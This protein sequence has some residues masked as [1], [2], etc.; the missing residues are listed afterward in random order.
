M[1]SFKNNNN[2]N[3][4][5]KYSDSPTV[6]RDINNQDNNQ[7]DID[8]NANNNNHSNNNNVNHNKTAS[9]SPN[10]LNKLQELLKQVNTITSTL[11]PTDRS[12]LHGSFSSNQGVGGPGQ[13]SNCDKE[14]LIHKFLN[15]T[16]QKPSGETT[17]DSV[18]I[19]NVQEIATMRYN[20]M[21]KDGTSKRV[22]G[23]AR[24]RN[25]TIEETIDTWADDGRFD[26]EIMALM[27]MGPNKSA[28]RSFMGTVNY[29]KDFIQNLASIAHPL[30]QLTRKSVPFIW[31][32][33]VQVAFDQVKC[34]VAN[35]VN[36]SLP[37]TNYPFYLEC[38]ASNI[39]IGSVLYQLINGQ[40]KVLAFMSRKLTG[41]PFYLFHP[42]T[43]GYISLLQSLGHFRLLHYRRLFLHL[44]FGACY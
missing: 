3:K 8:N 22:L 10:A 4:K 11:I 37:D 31:D 29:C 38:D 16:P 15:N 27:L 13:A 9:L 6:N 41:S 7:L 39:G 14:N 24:L 18:T 43:S 28:V 33:N 19:E 17:A 20:L 5:F 35:A 25:M 1:S 34:A 23:D 32:Q 36:L 40:R 2:N 21:L 30:Y 44:V 42:L 26:K 12:M